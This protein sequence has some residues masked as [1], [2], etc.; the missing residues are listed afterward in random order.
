MWLNT[1]YKLTLFIQTAN[2]ESELLHTYSK[3]D[4]L[5]ILILCVRL[6]V[7]VA[8]TLT[9]PVVLFPVTSLIL[10]GISYVFM[11]NL[12]SWWFFFHVDSASS[13]TVAVSWEAFP[14]G[15]SHSHRRVP[16]VCRQSACH[17]CSQYSRHLWH[18]W[19]VQQMNI[20][21]TFIGLYLVNLQ[22]RNHPYAEWCF[23]IE[24]KMHNN[25]GLK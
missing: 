16:P 9:V 23:T 8:V 20:K 14:L 1:F 12:S 6:A 24:N 10:V 5:D 11:M 4:P 13:V 15:S 3:V 18:H 17:L 2:T 7:L 25:K 22:I 21:V 19:W